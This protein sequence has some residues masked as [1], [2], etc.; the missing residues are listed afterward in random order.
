[1]DN[2]LFT[3][4]YKKCYKDVSNLS[5]NEIKKHWETI[6][7]KEGRLPNKIIFEQT[8]PDFNVK[9]WVQT[10][11][12]YIFT[13]K[14]EIYGWVYL[15]NKKNYKKYL[16][17]NGFVIVLDD[18]T[19]KPMENN[20][21]LIELTEIISK[22]NVK[23]LYVSKALKHFADRF[24]KKFN[25][26]KYNNIED[27]KSPAIFFG[28]YDQNDF[29][30]IV[31]HEGIKFLIWGGTDCDD[32]YKIRKNSIHVIKKIRNLSH[33]AISECIK[34][35][36]DKYSIPNQLVNFS[37]VDSNIFK[38]VPINALGDSIYIYNGFNK[39]NEYI[40]GESIY[41]KVVEEL[42]DFNF[43]YSNELEKSWESM[44]EVY[45]KCFIGLRLTD[46]DGNANTVQEF[47]S[48]NIPIIFN[49]PG[50]IGWKD[51]KDIIKTIYQYYQ[52]KIENI[53][54][55]DL[56]NSNNLIF[57]YTEMIDSFENIITDNM[58]KTSIELDCIIVIIYKNKI[59]NLN[60]T[61]YYNQNNIILISEEMLYNFNDDFITYYSNINL[62]DSSLIYITHYKLPYL[63]KKFQE[64]QN[65]IY[66]D[67]N[68]LP[69]NN[70]DDIIKNNYVENIINEHTNIYNN[71]SG[72][73]N[74]F[75]K[76]NDI[77]LDY[78][79]ENNILDYIIQIKKDDNKK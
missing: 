33:I 38:P 50:G 14:Y 31:E 9:E 29:K 32:R 66:V 75:S 22:S 24:K 36:L 44:P 67:Y 48:M 25:L 4:F 57:Y 47:N 73:E 20:S 65:I 59:D 74:Y 45:S 7:I 35:R 77:Y 76:F 41:K 72:D 8:Y 43:I 2:C 64:F 79:I 68:N 60:I 15:K 34:T 21:E 10:N 13:S 42:S 62:N 40:Y 51:N 18:N 49:G 56:I 70:I 61:D 1:M 30:N 71:I 55:N 46:G 6:G 39:G 28:V 3:S 19:L 78:L 23:K 54:D 16:S 26:E 12:K 27:I 52:K 58:L 37:L 63:L 11:N 53:Y 5:D 17:S 69:I